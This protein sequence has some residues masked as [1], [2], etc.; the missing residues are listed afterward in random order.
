MLQYLA[1]GL[2]L[3]SM[4]GLGAVGL[5]LTYSILRFANFTQCDLVAWGAYLALSV[6]AAL[7]GLVA[8]L[9]TG[10]LGPF[11]FGWIL[12]AALLGGA[13]LTVLRRPQEAGR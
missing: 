13:A 10:P 1:D 8:G 7:G 5:T 3:G 12:P 9:G 2:V 4:I 6:T 11:S